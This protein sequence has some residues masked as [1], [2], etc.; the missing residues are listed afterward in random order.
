MTH[1]AS[2]VLPEMAS[3]LLP[4]EKRN[5]RRDAGNLVGA[6]REF[7]AG[8]PVS[9]YPARVKL[10]VKSDYAVR[11][12]LSLARAFGEQKV[13]RA[14]EIAT[15]H[16]LRPNYLVQILIELKAKQIVRSVRGK[17]GGYLLARAPSQITLGDIL[18]AVHGPLFDAPA[19]GDPG[20]PPE[21]RA[22][23]IKLQKAAEQAAD[24]ISF[25]QLLEEGAE[26]EKM[27]YI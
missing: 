10:S 11:A 14:E 2:R 8:H 20:C 19:L 9:A 7:V 17:E 27:Y 26:K 5:S 18:R 23:W 1:R 12:V 24:S 4:S 15:E 22:A 21:I 16:G 25:Q 6:L 3:G 13:C